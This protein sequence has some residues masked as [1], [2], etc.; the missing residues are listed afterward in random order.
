MQSGGWPYSKV[1]RDSLKAPICTPI[2]PNSQTTTKLFNI[3]SSAVQKAK[4][5]VFPISLTACVENMLPQ[6]HHLV[7]TCVCVL[8]S[9][10][11]IWRHPSL[12]MLTV[13]DRN[14]SII[15]QAWNWNKL[16]FHSW[17]ELFTRCLAINNLVPCSAL[18][19]WFQ[20]TTTFSVRGWLLLCC[21]WQDL[22]TFIKSL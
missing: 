14:L 11:I 6:R 18:F 21:L 13:Q 17:Y 2:Q 4:D 5:I 8:Y 9:N 3:C 1:G 22:Y 15:E 12:L 10:Q 20:V 7:Y 19:N 16:V